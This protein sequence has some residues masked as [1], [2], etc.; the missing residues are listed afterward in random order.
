MGTVNSNSS[1]VLL[2]Q[3]LHIQ[4]QVRK[5]LNLKTRLKEE[6]MNE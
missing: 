3:A 5:T 6:N 2:L 4:F 1:Y